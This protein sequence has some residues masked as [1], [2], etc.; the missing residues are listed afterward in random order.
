MRAAL[1][2]GHT[3][4]FR[5]GAATLDMPLHAREVGKFP[6]AKTPCSELV[7]GPSTLTHLPLPH[8]HTCN[9]LTGGDDLLLARH[10]DEDVPK[11]RLQVDLNGLSHGTLHIVLT[12]VAGEEQVNGK[13][14]AGNAEHGN[15]AEEGGKL[16]G[17]HCG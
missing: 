10:E 4:S 8:A 11:R 3:C 14:A 12:V 15:V 17:I 16:A 7:K 6:Y 1:Y 2:S 5:I 9:H 13:S